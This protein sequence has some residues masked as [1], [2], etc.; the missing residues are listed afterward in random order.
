MDVE[1]EI[2]TRWKIEGFQAIVNQLKGLGRVS[3]SYTNNSKKSYCLCNLSVELI[4]KICFE[5]RKH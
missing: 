4:K 2:Q 3:V 5:N 1:F